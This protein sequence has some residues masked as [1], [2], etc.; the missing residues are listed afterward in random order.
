M[1]LMSSISKLTTS[2]DQL[3]GEA[4]VT[5]AALDAK[6][7]LADAAVVATQAEQAA[8]EATRDEAAAHAAEADTHLATVKTDANYQGISAF[9]AEKAMTAV[10]VFVYDT[11][12]DSDGGAWCKRCQHTSWY[13]EPLN[14]PERGARREFPAVAVIVTE[15]NRVTIYDGDDPSLPMWMTFAVYANYV[16]TMITGGNDPRTVRACAVNAKMVVGTQNEAAGNT[17]TNGL[18][19]V[20]FIADQ[21]RKIGSNVDKIYKG[22]I[23]DRNSTVGN[24]YLNNPNTGDARLGSPSVYSVDVAVLPDAP[25]DPATGLPVPTILAV[26]GRSDIVHGIS[27]LKDDGTVVDLVNYV[28][29]PA[30]AAFVEVGGETK[31]FTTSRYNNWIGLFDIPDADFNTGPYLWGFQHGGGVTW[32]GQRFADTDDH[33]VVGA[34]NGVVLFNKDEKLTNLQ[35]ASTA[36]R[37]QQV[38]AVIASGYATGWL[39]GD[40][41]GAFLADTDTTSLVG[42]VVAQDYFDDGIDGW[43]TQTF[44][45]SIVSA[46]AGKLRVQSQPD[47]NYAFASRSFTGLEVGAA[48]QLSIDIQVNAKSAL[49]YVGYPGGS[50]SYH[51]NLP[52]GTGTRTVKFIARSST[53][54]VQPGAYLPDADVEFDNLVVERADHDRSV[55]DGHLVVNGTITRSPVAAGAELVGYSG[56]SA[57]NYLEQPYDSALDFGTGDFCAMG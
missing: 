51:T 20:D 56:F 24:D 38:S 53:L 32:F 49:L 23:A 27:V 26:C 8:T 34:N 46:Y 33:L 2:V 1:T 30:R 35:G 31:I 41:K 52:V 3:T 43:G 17:G 13:N 48:Y 25:S 7:T 45:N 9:L 16:N 47:Q 55:H 28:S 10:H 19:I 57:A 42:G 44:Y 22:T 18:F 54:N 14:T 11:S 6:V 5:K 39:P 12:L 37:W 4:N 15:T 21:G 36:N 29:Q 50:A 40:I